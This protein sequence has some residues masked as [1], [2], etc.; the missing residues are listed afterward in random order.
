M[1]LGAIATNPIVNRRA[2]NL[3]VGHTDLTGP[4]LLCQGLRPRALVLHLGS[5]LEKTPLELVRPAATPLNRNY[6]AGC[7]N[8][9]S[10]AVF[11]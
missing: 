6:T 8:W 9:S 11:L 2:V 4:L 5:K 3:N 7:A 1:G 10:C